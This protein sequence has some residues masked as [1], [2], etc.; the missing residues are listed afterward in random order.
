[1]ILFVFIFILK[2]SAITLYTCN[3]YY[4]DI[5]SNMVII[6]IITWILFNVCHRSTFDSELKNVIAEATRILYVYMRFCIPLLCYLTIPRSG[7]I[8]NLDILFPS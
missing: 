7:C 3:L 5:Y 4:F 1:M 8:L 6:I 2:Q